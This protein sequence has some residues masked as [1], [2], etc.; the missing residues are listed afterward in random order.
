MKKINELYTVDNF[1][2]NHP[3]SYYPRPS[4][5][6]SEEYGYYLNLNGV[7]NY[8]IVKNK[9]F[10]N[11]SLYDNFEDEIVVPYAIESLLS[12]VGKRLGV[13]EVL[14]YKKTFK[15]KAKK[16]L[17]ILH[18]GAVDNY[19]KV[20]L[21]KEYVGE[22][23]GGYLDFSF[24]ISKYLKE[25]NELI[26]LVY[27]K[28]DY[29]YPYG[30]QRKKNGGI[31]YTP[32]SGIWKSVWIESVAAE[33]IRNIKIDTNIDDKTLSLSIDES[34]CEEKHLQ[35]YFKDE[36]IKNVSFNESNIT[37]KFDEISLWS[38]E[39]PN[40]YTFKIKTITDTVESYFG[41]RKVSIGFNKGYNV[42]YLNNKPYFMHGLLDQGYYSDGLYTPAALDV[43]INDLTNIKKLGFNTL[44]KHIK[45]EDDMWYYL[46]DKMGIIVWQDAVNN[47]KYRFIADTALPTLGART[48]NLNLSPKKE[49]KENFI[50]HTKEMIDKLYNHPSI[51]LWTI[52]N[53]GWGQFETEKTFNIIKEFDKT[54]LYDAASGWF[55]DF[56]TPLTSLHIY[57]KEIEIKD[58]TLRPIIISEFGGYSLKVDG[59]IYSAKSFGYKGFKSKEELNAGLKE[60]YERDIIGNMK[61]GVCAAIYTQVSD[62]EE[63]ING[64]FTYDRKVVKAD[65]NTFIDIANKL[66]F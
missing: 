9:D 63:E 25:E 28:L 48:K 10:N 17:S 33:Y 2:R 20:Y 8:K 40:L 5:K 36:L 31:W 3:L 39:E 27:D 12:G 44:R 55:K 49:V 22:H 57:F 59:H 65:F 26:V 52:F 1:D 60:L 45:V 62:V 11:F 56:D 29:K 58:F 64:L 6:R 53:E 38:P 7:W 42:I 66:K 32:S 15:Y 41:F 16:D 50:N 24:D 54:R 23:I 51:V 61:N 30:K 21:N 13:D 14:V 19:C 34:L 18:F 47:G 43:V 37:I 35:I 46:C 4:L